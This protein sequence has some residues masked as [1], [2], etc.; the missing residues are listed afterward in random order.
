MS[1]IEAIKEMEIDTFDDNHI[2]FPQTTQNSPIGI[3]D[4]RNFTI[5]SMTL[6]SKHQQTQKNN[7]GLFVKKAPKK[8]KMRESVENLDLFSS[9]GIDQRQTTIS[10]QVRGSKQL[11]FLPGIN[12]K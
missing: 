2:N 10:P 5:P 9:Y 6:T 8:N 3:E 11:A 7:L 4:S 12:L 1:F